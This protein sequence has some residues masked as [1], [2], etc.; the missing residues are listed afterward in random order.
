[1]TDI[2]DQAPH[3]TSKCAGVPRTFGTRDAGRLA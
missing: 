2:T 3:P 1:M